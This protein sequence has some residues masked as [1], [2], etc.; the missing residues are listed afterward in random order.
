MIRYHIACEAD[1]SLPGTFFYRKKR[2]FASQVVGMVIDA[3]E[4]IVPGAIVEVLDEAGLPARATKTN[5]LGQFFSTTPLKRGVY[6][7]NIDKQGL[8]FD[9]I[10]LQLTGQIV[11][12]LK[13]Q[14]KLASS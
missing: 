5:Q 2:F 10:E 4:K 3:A 12:P 14:A 1:S 6:R 7:I 11:E 8:D 13:I 9:T